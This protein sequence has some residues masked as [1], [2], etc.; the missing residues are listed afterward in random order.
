MVPERKVLIR[1]L[2]HSGFTVEYGDYFLVF[3]YFKQN[4]P[5]PD[6]RHEISV[7]KRPFVFVSHGHYDHYNPIIFKWKDAN[8]NLRY[9]VSRDV[10]VQSQNVRDAGIKNA[11][12]SCI[13]MEPYERI[14]AGGIAVSAYGSTDIGVSFLLDVNG[15]RIFHA[16]D[17]NWWHWA[18]E[19]T[20]EELGEE[21]EK[22]KNEVSRLE[23]ERIDILFFPVDPRLG[24]YYWLGGGYMMEKFHPGLFVPMHFADNPGITR[25]FAEKM[26]DTG[27]KIAE[28]SYA[29]QVFE[30]R[31]S[32]RNGIVG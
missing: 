8:P 32:R 24:E 18:E 23:R 5:M 19:S 4:S 2:Y 10:K 27:G 29:G 13:F 3:D 15:L 17:L 12:S 30:Y 26:A 20:A 9:I 7:H 6:I 14:E 22:F 28:I 25:R 11:E 31:I 1:Y 21:E 16:G